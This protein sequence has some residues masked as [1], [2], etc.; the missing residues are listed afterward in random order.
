VTYQGY[1]INRYMFYIKQQDKKNMYQNSGVRVAAYDVMDQDKSMYYDQ[2]K[3][4]E[5]LNFMI[6]RFL[7]SVAT[8]L[9]ESRVF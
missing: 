9:T 8:R 6:L 1:D 4:F 5:S 3:G 7:F 2:I